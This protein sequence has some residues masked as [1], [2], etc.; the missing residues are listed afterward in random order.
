[1]GADRRQGVVG[2]GLGE[3]ALVVADPP[4]Q[5]CGSEV[6][7]CRDA[8]SVRG[9]S[10]GDRSRRAR[11]Q[12]AG[13]RRRPAPLRAMS[14]PTSTNSSGATRL[15]CSLSREPHPAEHVPQRANR[16]VH[17]LTVSAGGPSST[18][19]SIL[20]HVSSRRPLIVCLGGAVRAGSDLS[21]V[22]QRA[23]AARRCVRSRE[24]RR[25]RQK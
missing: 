1:M 12:R 16:R 21:A 15:A 8:C 17:S 11:C 13:W 4:V 19:A 5:L 7:E 23:V 14:T 24:L 3:P 9:T 22:L 25:G 18:W 10:A 20:G 2:G 6:E